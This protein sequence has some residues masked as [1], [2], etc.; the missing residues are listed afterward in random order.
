MQPINHISRTRNVTTEAIDIINRLRNQLEE[1]I[2]NGF[3]P[4]G[5]NSITEA[6]FIPDI[7][8]QEADITAEQYHTAMKTIAMFLGGLSP[9]DLAA[10]FA[11][12]RG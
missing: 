3:A 9:D 7:G 11:L 2:L 1:Y 12:R 8:G 5:K 10:L 6:N 4:D